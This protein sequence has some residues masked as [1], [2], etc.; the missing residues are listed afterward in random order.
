MTERLSGGEM[1]IRA[2]Q[3]EGV[4]YI[5]GY[6]GGAALHIYDAIFKQQRIEH[7]LVRHEQAA[8]HIATAHMD[9]IPIVVISARAVVDECYEENPNPTHRENCEL[10]EWGR[11]HAQI[12]FGRSALAVSSNEQGL[13]R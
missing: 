6:P 4:E 8:T 10:A 7:I 11:L 2:L 1:L 3:D 12:N 13:C 5:F 9:S